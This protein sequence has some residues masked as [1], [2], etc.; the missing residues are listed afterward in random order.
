MIITHFCALENVALVYNAPWMYVK[1]LDSLRMV[2]WFIEVIMYLLYN[3]SLCIMNYIT[4]SV[5]NA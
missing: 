4:L 3:D 5:R 2:A 1:T